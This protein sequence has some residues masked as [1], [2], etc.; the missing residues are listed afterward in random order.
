MSLST[1]LPRLV[2]ADPTAPA[3]TYYD[4]ASGERIEL[5]ARVL[6]MW[7]SKA[8][9]WLTEE[10]LVE[11]GSA[12]LLD[13]PARHWRQ[14]YWAFGVWLV[15]GEVLTSDPEHRAD[16]VVTMDGAGSGAGDLIEPERALA[17]SELTSFPDR[18]DGFAAAGADDAALDGA[19]HAHLEADMSDP[20][21]P[22]QARRLMFTDTD[23][24]QTIRQVVRTLGAGGS[25]VLVRNEDPAL[26]ADRA[27]AEAA[28]QA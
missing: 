3:L 25:V 12:V 14:I 1:I 13:L 6:T 23:A 8:A 7:A 15:G 9:H 10:M 5:S 4:D 27:A 22:T 19:D 16:V 17:P 21:S 18:F 28:E 11:P 2:G 26:R 24:A 20:N